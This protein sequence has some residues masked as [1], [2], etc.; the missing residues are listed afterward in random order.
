MQ[1]VIK[2]HTLRETGTRFG[3][4][5]TGE[6]FRNKYPSSSDEP[7]IYMKVK[8]E[9]YPGLANYAVSLGSGLIFTFATTKEI[10]RVKTT[11]EAADA[12]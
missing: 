8:R 11:I 2:Y 1:P 3:D 10:I 6:I 7:A 9:G 4:L 12:P 5:N